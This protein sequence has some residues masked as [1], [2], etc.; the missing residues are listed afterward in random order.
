MSR[1]LDMLVVTMFVLLW[2]DVA[3]I[4]DEPKPVVID[5]WGSIVDPDGDCAIKGDKFKLTIAVPGTAHDLH[6]TRVMNAPR[7]LHE[8]DGDFSGTVKVT[9]PLNPGK[10]VV[11][12]G[13]TAGIYAGLLLWAGEKDFIRLERN[14]RWQRGGSG[15][16]VDFSPGFEY[17]KGG[18]QLFFNPYTKPD[19]F[20]GDSTWLRLER[21]GTKVTAHHSL[22]GMAWSAFKELETALPHKVQIGVSVL[23]TGDTPVTA[24][25]TEFKIESGK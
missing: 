17:W 20:K 4:G 10:K 18:T 11:G 13:A 24:E 16:L 25:F 23:N 5:G 14:A 8:V 6:P 7:V 12:K 19:F 21:K 1:L 15:K 22:D 9:C 3:V 2:C